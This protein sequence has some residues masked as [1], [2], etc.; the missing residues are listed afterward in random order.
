MLPIINTLD[1]HKSQLLS[2]ESRPPPPTTEHSRVEKLTG[3]LSTFLGLKGNRR[4]RGLRPSSPAGARHRPW[5]SLPA[6]I[7]LTPRGPQRSRYKS[8]ADPR[9]AFQHLLINFMCAALPQRQIIRSRRAA[10]FQNSKLLC[11]HNLEGG[12]GASSRASGL[13]RLAA[14]L[15]WCMFVQTVAEG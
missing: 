15:A 3:L 9:G 4:P 12:E 7:H 14:G 6:V 8:T 11:C 1:F 10:V 5:S 13:S 2:S